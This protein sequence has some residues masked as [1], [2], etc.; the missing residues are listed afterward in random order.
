M[1]YGELQEKINYAFRD[2]SL[3]DVAMTHSSYANEQNLK[4]G[5]KRVMHNET[6]EFLGDAVLGFTI[7][8][9]LYGASPLENEGSL[10]RKRATVVCE[11]SLA[12]CARALGIGRLIKLGKSTDKAKDRD[13]PSI[14]S[15][16]ME[17]LFAAVYLD[18]GIEMAKR[19][20]LSTLES[21]VRAS[22][23][24]SRITDYKTCLQEQLH[25]DKI[26]DIE[27]AVIREIGPDHNKTFTSSVAAS[28]RVL[29][30]GSGSSKKES[31]QN[32]ARAALS[33]RGTMPDGGGRDAG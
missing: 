25:N 15:D 20:I 13:K 6:L 27:Y 9:H 16:A 29:G 8:E 23:T 31:E 12:D 19:V 11:R 28:G 10:S 5:A 21:A 7:A 4:C 3:L 30:T 32:A 14:L 22:M 17:A 2:L 33:A 1:Q 26:T 24:V 18:G